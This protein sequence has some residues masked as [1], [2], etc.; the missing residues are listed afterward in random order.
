MRQT[1]RQVER[2]TG[3]RVGGLL[4]LLLC[5]S[6]LISACSGTAGGASTGGSSTGAGSNG[7]GGAATATPKP[8]KTPP[9]PATSI[10]VD[11][12]DTS[13]TCYYVTSTQNITVDKMVLIVYLQ[14][15]T[16]PKPITQQDIAS[17]MAQMSQGQAQSITSFT[18]VSGVGD[19]AAF[20]TVSVPDGPVSQVFVFYTLTGSILSICESTSVTGSSAATQ[21][22]ELQQCAQKVVN[23]L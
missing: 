3:V 22:S 11:T 12:S 9:T 2:S 17:A 5:V 19:Q 13:G 7:S 14:T 6:L 20:M 21:Q 10:V 15:W 23:A 1:G 4:A 18:N 8:A 16:G